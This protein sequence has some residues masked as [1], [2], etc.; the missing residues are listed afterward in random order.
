MT[1]RVLITAGASA[2]GPAIARGF[3][4]NGA[5]VHICDIDHRPPAEAVDAHENITGSVTGVGVA[6]QPIPI[7]GDS[8]STR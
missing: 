2:I 3:A 1:Q 7:D 8:T 6:R 5:R 4:T